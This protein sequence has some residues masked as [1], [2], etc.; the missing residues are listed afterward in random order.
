MKLLGLVALLVSFTGCA[1]MGA[2]SDNSLPPPDPA[3]QAIETQ[4]TMDMQ[5]QALQQA[6]DQASTATM[7][8]Q[9]DPSTTLPPPTP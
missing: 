5:N 4:N 2:S 1:S 6:Q 8:A 9:P 7:Q 3:Q